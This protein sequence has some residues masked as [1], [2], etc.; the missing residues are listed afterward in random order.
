MLPISTYGL[1]RQPGGALPQGLRRLQPC[2]ILWTMT[3]ATDVVDTRDMVW[4]HNALRGEF[5]RL[6]SELSAFAGSDP[7]AWSRYLT[8]W[9]LMYDFLVEHHTGEDDLLWPVLNQR[10]PEQHDIITTMQTEHHTLHQL[11]EDVNAQVRQLDEAR[12][13]G[14]GDLDLL[15]GDCDEMFAVMLTEL[16]KH[17]D[18]E[19]ER[20]LPLVP[21]VLTQ[22]EWAA[23]PAEAAEILGERNSMLVLGYILKWMPEDERAIM[24]GKVPPPVAAGWAETGSAMFADYD[25]GLSLSSA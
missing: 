8:H 21:G 10:L 15:A 1:S 20:L 22:E 4:V 12:D 25:A 11:L 7:A 3:E 14:T 2:S 9:T 16:R 13:G 23:L 24:L 18:D 5:E 17:L 19:E 6:R